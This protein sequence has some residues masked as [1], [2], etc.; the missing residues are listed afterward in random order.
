MKEIWP[1]YSLPLNTLF[2]GLPEAGTVGLAESHGD[3]GQRRRYSPGKARA[4]ELVCT[5]SCQ[6]GEVEASGVENQGGQVN[7]V[8]VRQGGNRMLALDLATA[9]AGLS[10]TG[11]QES[12][13]PL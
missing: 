12:R 1:E 5:V 6:V 13:L 4:M 3:Q 10:L 7:H 8:A 2:Q 9:S 11:V